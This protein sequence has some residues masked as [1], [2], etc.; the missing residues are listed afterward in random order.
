MI[1]YSKG[2]LAK[3]TKP[4]LAVAIAQDHMLRK[5]CTKGA[6]MNCPSELLALIKPE[7]KLVRCAGTICTAAPMNS[8]MLVNPAPMADKMPNTKKT[9]VAFCMNGI[10]SKLPTKNRNPSKAT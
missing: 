8:E 2:I 9:P 10:I 6:K 3:A 4:K 1:Q 7:T 5:N